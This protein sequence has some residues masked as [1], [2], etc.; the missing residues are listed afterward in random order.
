MSAPSIM[1]APGSRT[2]SPGCRCRRASIAARGDG[3]EFGAD[4]RDDLYPAGDSRTGKTEHA[5]AAVDRRQGY[6]G[7]KQHGAATGP[8]HPGQLSRDGKGSSGAYA[9][10]QTGGV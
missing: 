10:W 5:G 3:M 9:A 4:L 6:D 8:R 7:K 1:P 2:M